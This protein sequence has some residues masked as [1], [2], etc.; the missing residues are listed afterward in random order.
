[1][2]SRVLNNRI[3]DQ[4]KQNISS[5]ISKNNTLG[6]D[7][8]NKLL[9]LHPA[10]T[11]QFLSE[12]EY[13][14]FNKLFSTFPIE[15]KIKVFKFFS[16][17]LRVSTLNSLDDANKQALLKATHTDELID[18]FDL[19]SDSDLKHYFGL[20]Q[21]KE[22][23][24]VLSLMK[25]EPESAGGIMDIDFITFEQNFTVSSCTQLLQ[26]L[27]PN[28]DLHKLIYITNANYQLLGH[29]KLEELLTKKPSDNIKSFMHKNDLIL[30]VNEDQETVAQKM[31]HYQLTVA[32]VVG[33]NDILLG[34]I[35]AETLID[36]IEEESSEDIYKMSA[37]TPIKATY[38]DTPFLK[39]LYERSYIL[40]ALLLV[41]SFS[42][43]ILHSYERAIVGLTIFIPM[44]ISAGGNTSS[45][46]SALSIQRLASG[47]IN[48]SN[49]KKFIKRELVMALV[50]ALV[51]GL[52][53]F[54][55]VQVSPNANIFKSLSV[56]IT[57]CIIV[58]LSVALGSSIPLLLK[59][60]NIDPAFSAGP[61]LA[62]LM[63]ILGIMIFCYISQLIL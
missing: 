13:S 29:I 46:T 41:E 11:A 10:D 14:T 24:Q 53:G 7:L 23:E 17:T 58:M 18:L 43:I 55:R 61:F 57:L 3:F 60:F 12:L 30:D 59:R 26:R 39:L 62:T 33:N 37:M 48:K 42:S 56:S 44:L 8:W 34:I 9:I 40:I 21:K 31:N 5:V 28:I 22:R 20:L 35:S 47:E 15:H 32:P 54:I 45:Q 19:M 6:E 1:V 16:D 50:I 63:D 25:F 2:G 27:Q 51:L 36:I 49:I 4:I 38:F 52:V